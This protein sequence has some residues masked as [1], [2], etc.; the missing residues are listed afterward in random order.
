M[1][2]YYRQYNN[3]KCI[4]LGRHFHF[5]QCLTTCMMARGER[6]EY[7]CP[8]FLSEQKTHTHGSQAQC[9]LHTKTHFCS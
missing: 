9:Y 8:I 4:V 2:L 5:E 1:K 3:Y 7:C 6:I